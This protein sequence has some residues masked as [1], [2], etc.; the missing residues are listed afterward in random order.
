MGGERAADGPGELI[1]ATSPDLEGWLNVLRLWPGETA[2]PA[3]TTRPLVLVETN[4]E[5]ML[6]ERLPVLETRLRDARA[7]DVW[8]STMQMKKGRPGA[9]ITAVADRAAKQAAVT[10]MLTH[11][12]ILR[13]GTTPLLRCEVER[14]VPRFE[15]TQGPA[16][17]K[18][19]RLPDDP[20]SVAPEYESARQL[21]ER[22]RLPLSDVH[23]RP[24]EE[25]LARLRDRHDG[26]DAPAGGGER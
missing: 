9:K 12:S 4:V 2:A 24:S 7:R 1:G 15:S 23:R 11:S 3:R 16:A 22:S 10:E 8:Y 18:V 5:D 26:D 21:A 13:V 17:V 14:E 25:A 6:D 20:R 19:K